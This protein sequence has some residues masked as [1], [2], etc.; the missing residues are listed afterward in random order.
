MEE[1]IIIET[2]VNVGI[3]RQPAVNAMTMWKDSNINESYI[4]KIIFVI[5]F[6]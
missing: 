5:I 2:N 6:Y 4:G 3:N 1:K